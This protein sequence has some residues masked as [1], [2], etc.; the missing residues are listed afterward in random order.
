MAVETVM[1]EKQQGGHPPFSYYSWT[2]CTGHPCCVSA[3]L[4]QRAKCSLDATGMNGASLFTSVAGRFETG[5]FRAND[6]FAYRGCEHSRG[7]NTPIVETRPTI[8]APLYCSRKII[9]IHT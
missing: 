9:F 5:F 2:Q 4:L 8:A 3:P 1:T 6:L 7:G